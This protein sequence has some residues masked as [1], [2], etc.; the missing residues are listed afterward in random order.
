[1]PKEM[2]TPP[3]RVDICP[4]QRT[5]H[6]R[7]NRD[8]V[9]EPPDRRAVAQK[10]PPRGATR[11]VRLKINRKGEADFGRQGE[12]CP[13]TAL[14]TDSDYA[15]LPI[16]VLQIQLDD[17]A[18]SQAQTGKEKQNGVVPPSDWAILIMVSK[19]LWHSAGRQRFW[20]GRK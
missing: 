1:M 12:L 6:D 19:N 2:G 13:A 9:S 18:G 17:C 20:Y 10:Y 4:D 11:T 15:V 7:R 14:A 5:T 16:E 8:R 3:F